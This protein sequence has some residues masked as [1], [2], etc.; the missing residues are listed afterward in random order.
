MLDGV[1]RWLVQATGLEPKLLTLV[2]ILIVYTASVYRSVQKK[3][4]FIE[5]GAPNSQ[6][7]HGELMSAV[8]RIE[9]GLETVAKYLVNIDVRPQKEPS[10][11]PRHEYEVFLPKNGAGSPPRSHHRPENGLEEEELYFPVPGRTRSDPEP[12]FFLPLPIIERDLQED[13]AT[14]EEGSVSDLRDLEAGL[15]EPAQHSATVSRTLEALEIERKAG[16]IVP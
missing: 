4:V 10:F 5:K 7:E 1:L 8:A 14:V 2:G 16:R 13:V 3:V 12:D 15:L 11:V 6:P 9:G